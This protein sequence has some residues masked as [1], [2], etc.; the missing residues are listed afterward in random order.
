M[1]EEFLGNRR[2]T[3]EEAFFANHNKTLLHRLKQTA[4]VQQKKAALAAASGISDD[5]ALE[6]LVALDIDSDTLAA[7]SLVP[8]LKVAWADG[9]IDDKERKAALSAA[10]EIGLSNGSVSHALFER[11]IAQPPSAELFRAWREYIGALLATM[12]EDARRALRQDIL[13]RARNMAEATGGFLGIGRKVS[14]QEEAALKE[15]AAA[16]A[17][18]D[19]SPRRG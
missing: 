14:P 12:D 15:L 1:S 2:K 5:N 4:S 13:D 6:K 11:W 9:A 19:E 3:L 17:E 16:F 7:L 10:A 8:I 18:P